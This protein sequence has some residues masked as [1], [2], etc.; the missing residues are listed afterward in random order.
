MTK[1]RAAA[2]APVL[3]FSRTGVF[4]E[5][6]P[7]MRCAAMLVVGCGRV[8]RAIRTAAARRAIR[9]HLACIRGSPKLR[10]WL[11]RTNLGN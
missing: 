2:A 1:N 5:N 10:V 6:D 7:I 3:K 9:R 8:V 11:Y 4:P